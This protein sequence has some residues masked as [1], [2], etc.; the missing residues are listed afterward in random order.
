[1][2]MLCTLVNEVVG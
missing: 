1:M 2:Y